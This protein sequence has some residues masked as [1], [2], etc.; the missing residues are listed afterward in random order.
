MSRRKFETERRKWSRLPLAIPVFVRSRDEKGKEQLEFANALNVSAGG[1][2]VALRRSL[3]LSSRVSIEIPIAPLGVATKLPKVS[4]NFLAQALRI[5]YAE[6]C[7]LV[8]LKFSHPLLNG[9]SS[10]PP[11]QRKSPSTK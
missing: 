5:T 3:P 2:L 8:G 9:S 6:G 7:N 10:A 4:R 1:A 11:R